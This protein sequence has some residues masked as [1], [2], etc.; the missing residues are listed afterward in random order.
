[1]RTDPHTEHDLHLVLT[2][3]ET[4]ADGGVRLTLRRVTGGDLPE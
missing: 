4:V 1:M 3:K 2:T